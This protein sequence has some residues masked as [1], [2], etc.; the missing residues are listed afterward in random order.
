[1]KCAVSRWADED[2]C[3]SCASDLMRGA[4]ALRDRGHLKDDGAPPDPV[5][6]GALACAVLSCARACG[7]FRRPLWVEST[8]DTSRPVGP[9][10]PPARQGPLIERNRL[11]GPVLTLLLILT[12]NLT[13]VF[14]V[15][16]GLGLLFVTDLFAVW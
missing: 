6:G 8:L 7:G 5:S 14:G 15:G 16:G 2:D 13:L 10:A 1:V 11:S 4:H 12:L 3:Q 9:A